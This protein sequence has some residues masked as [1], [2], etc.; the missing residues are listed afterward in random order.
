MTKRT[1]YHCTLMM[2]DLITALDG[3]DGLNGLNGLDGLDL[4]MI[5][6]DLT[7]ASCFI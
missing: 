2:D 4:D 6:S 1:H 7:V 3:L 5:A